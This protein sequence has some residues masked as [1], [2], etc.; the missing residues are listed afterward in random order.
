MGL[1]GQANPSHI[2]FLETHR[3]CSQ[4]QQQRQKALQ[5]AVTA[6]EHKFPGLCGYI[7]CFNQ[8]PLN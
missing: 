7:K 6:G 8:I 4:K 3:P 1:T 5:E 2:P